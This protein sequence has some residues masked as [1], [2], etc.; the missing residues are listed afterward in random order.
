[1]FHA[2]ACCAYLK[3]FFPPIVTQ[4]TLFIV[5]QHAQCPC[6][7]V[8]LAPKA[9]LSHASRQ[10]YTFIANTWLVQDTRCIHPRFTHACGLWVVLLEHGGG[11]L[12]IFKSPICTYNQSWPFVR[13]PLFLSLS[14]RNGRRGILRPWSEAPYR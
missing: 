8:I 11:A 6:R 7:V 5:V 14:K 10:T 13:F 9:L 12:G 2:A 3:L 1:M 4:Q